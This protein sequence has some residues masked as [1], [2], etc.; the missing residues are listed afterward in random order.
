MVG[1]ANTVYLL[2]VQ[3]SQSRQQWMYLEGSFKLLGTTE[4][5]LTDYYTKAEVYNKD[6]MDATLGNA[7]LTTTAQTIKGAINELDNDV[8]EV[9]QARTDVN[10]VIHANLKA[11]LDADCQEVIRARTDKDGITHTNLKE[12]FIAIEDN[13]D[14]IEEVIGDETQL[15]TK[16]KIV[17]D[18]INELQA[19]LDL[20]VGGNGTPVGGIVPF[21]GTVIPNGFLYCRGQEVSR[22]DYAELFEVIGTTYG[23]GD[24]VETFNVP[25]LQGRIPVG[26]DVNQ[27]LSTDI[28]KA[29]GEIGG[30][31]KTL[32]SIENLPSHKHDFVGDSH[33]HTFTGGLHSHTFTGESHT[34][35]FTG[36]SHNHGLDGNALTSQSTNVISNNGTY[37]PMIHGVTSSQNDV[38]YDG[39]KLYK[40]NGDYE[41]KNDVD[42]N[43]TKSV[44]QTVSAT[45]GGTNSSETTG[46]TISNV[47]SGTEFSIAQ[48]YLA[49]DYIICY[50][51]NTKNIDDVTIDPWIANVNYEVDAVVYRNGAL[52]KCLTAHLSEQDFNTT[53]RANWELIA[54]NDMSNVPEVVDARTDVEGNAYTTLSERLNADEQEVIDARTNADGDVFTT[55]GERLDDMDDRMND[56]HNWQTD[57]EYKVGDCVAYDR[58][59]W[60]AVQDHTSTGTKISSVNFEKLIGHDVAPDVQNISLISCQN[61]VALEIRN[62]VVFSKNSYYGRSNTTTWHFLVYEGDAV[63]A[64]TKG[65]GTFYCKVTY[66]ADDYLIYE[67]NLMRTGGGN[68][69]DYATVKYIGIYWNDVFMGW[70][71]V[72][73]LKPYQRGV[74]YRQGEMVTYD[75]ELYMRL[76]DSVNFTGDFDTTEWKRF[77]TESDMQEVIDA[78]TDA[79][80]NTYTSLKERL[81]TEQANTVIS[82]DVKRI[83]L[84]DQ[85]PAVEEPGVLYLV[86]N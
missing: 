38:G 70:M 1:K 73:Y 62:R 4:V 80:G 30:N 12:H 35:T 86:K 76:A 18:A 20:K 69:P 8:K 53:E 84:V 58:Y 2:A 60:R 75:N 29:L 68:N 72:D 25:N 83:E 48:P 81:D 23:E 82:L 41:Y 85:L 40:D 56:I 36:T 46:G 19:Q 54:G 15:E 79:D 21:T 67:A 14:E 24:G 44:T 77:I 65:R 39:I 50:K 26:L 45:T 9:I 61:D 43:Y 5:D 11:R 28:A 51:R 57:T 47:G 32:L 33:A 52:Y 59:L 74:K 13:V 3:G 42:W 55:L 63:N 27:E 34:H 49:M 37:I 71:P 7:T 10:N 16:A 78:R 31:F 64:I 17:V 22:V 6:E 66:N